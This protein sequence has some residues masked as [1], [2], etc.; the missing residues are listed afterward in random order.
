MSIS[1]MK[2]DSCYL[3]NLFYYENVHKSLQLQDLQKRKYTDVTLISDDMVPHKAHKF[4]ISTCSALLKET[5]LRNPH[6]HPTIYLKGVK[7]QE[8]KYLL[9]LLY[10]G[11]AGVAYEHLGALFKVFDQL[12]MTAGFNRPEIPRVQPKEK[13]K[14]LFVNQI[15]KIFLKKSRQK[16]Y[17]FQC[18]ACDH[19]ATGRHTLRIH[20]KTVH[21]GVRYTCDQCDH[22]YKTKS[23]L[24]T[25]QDSVHGEIRY[26]C[27]FCGYQGTTKGNLRRHKERWHDNVRVRYQCDECDYKATAHSVLRYHQKRIHEGVIYNCENC[28]YKATAKSSLKMHQLSIHEGATYKCECCDFTA[29]NP[30][31]LRNHQRSDHEGIRYACNMCDYRA[32]LLSHLKR[33]QEKKHPES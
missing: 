5:L 21:F 9:Q 4:V 16:K 32:K 23:H 30:K 3:E 11:E 20:K 1:N 6:E 8:L 18:D 10:H 17:L 13:S 22:K 31:S 26:E 33:H 2:Q 19:K 29:T 24:K 12:E 15:E 27:E 25:H 28:D 14:G 7:H